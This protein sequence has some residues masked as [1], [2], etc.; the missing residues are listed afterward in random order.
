M[1]V[2]GKKQT[3]ATTLDPEQPRFTQ[4]TGLIT[5]ILFLAP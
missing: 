2:V 4:M 5:V 3:Q 1:V